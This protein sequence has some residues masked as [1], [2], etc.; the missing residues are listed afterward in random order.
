MESA[1]SGRRGRS[2]RAS[3]SPCCLAMSSFV[4]QSL[5]CKEAEARA[6]DYGLV[7]GVFFLFFVESVKA[8]RANGLRVRF[9]ILLGNENTANRIEGS[10]YSVSR[11]PSGEHTSVP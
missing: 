4:I 7:N 5:H 1:Q 6:S 10:T 2:G 9:G 8:R 11:S 3:A